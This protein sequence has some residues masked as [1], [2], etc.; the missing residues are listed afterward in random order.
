MQSTGQMSTWTAV[1]TEMA[2]ASWSPCLRVLVSR[3]S[4]L[5]PHQPHAQ[6]L[7]SFGSFDANFLVFLPDCDLNMLRASPEEQKEHNDEEDKAHLNISASPLSPGCRLQDRNRINWIS[8]LWPQTPTDTPPPLPTTPLPDDYYEEAVPLDPGSAPQYFTTNMNSCV[9]MR[10][11]SLS[12]AY[13]SIKKIIQMSLF[14][15]SS[16]QELCGGW[17]LWRCR[18]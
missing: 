11:H 7:C 4:E 6:F 16:F 10:M 5:Q 1:S 15:I 3:S 17:L 12:V 9:K 13:R 18:Q 2:P 8:A 14:H